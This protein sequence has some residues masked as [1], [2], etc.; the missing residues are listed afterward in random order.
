MPTRN[1]AVHQE[2]NR[3]QGNGCINKAKSQIKWTQ[4][5]LHI[6]DKNAHIHKNNVNKV[7][8]NK[9]TFRKPAPAMWVDGNFRL[10][11]SWGDGAVEWHQWLHSSQRRNNPGKKRRTSNENGSKSSIIRIPKSPKTVKINWDRKEIPARKGL[12]EPTKFEVKVPGNGRDAS[13]GRRNK[14]WI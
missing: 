10:Q 5:P 9:T 1:F 13:G 2:S 14:H 12:N 8:D 11:P 6:A 3:E 4:N 7:M